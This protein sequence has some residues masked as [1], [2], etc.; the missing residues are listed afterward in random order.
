MVTAARDVRD[1]LDDEG[2]KGLETVFEVDVPPDRLLAV[3]WDP[4]S[5]PRLFPDVKSAERLRGDARTMVLA[6]RVDAVVREVRYVLERTLDRDAG[7]I[8]WREIGGDLRRVRGGWRA[9]ALPGGGSRVT[10]RAFLDVGW[11]VPV[12]L[13]REGARRKLG[14]MV[15]RVRALAAE[16]GSAPPG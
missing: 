5:F 11:F 15:E 7:T 13:V 9:E 1:V 16:L 14:E 12:G 8:V 10:Y 6:F 3:L 4:A 2:T